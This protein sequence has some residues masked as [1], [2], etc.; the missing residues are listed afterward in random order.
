M[1]RWLQ[2]RNRNC[3]SVDCLQIYRRAAAGHIGNEMPAALRDEDISSKANVA[4]VS[5]ASSTPAGASLLVTRI[6]SKENAARRNRALLKI[7]K[8]Q[9]VNPEIKLA[10][11][12]ILDLLNSKSDYNVAW[13]SAATIAKRLRR[14][15]RSGQ[16]YVKTIKELG[17]FQCEQLSPRD[18]IALCESR[19]GFRPKLDR[20]IK[21]GPNLYIVNP[22]HPLW[23]KQKTLPENV[24]REMGEVIRKIKAMRN[25]KT[26]SHLASDPTN[27][28]KRQAGSNPHRAYCLETIRERLR[29]T[30]DEFRDDDANDQ[31][32]RYEE[33]QRWCREEAW[34]DDV[35]D[36]IDGVANDAQGFKLSFVA[37]ERI[38]HQPRRIAHGR[39]YIGPGCRSGERSQE[40][41]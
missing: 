6:M 2:R 38:S 22:E 5:V 25:A 39:S 41:T 21:Y 11:E 13:P 19:F 18:A 34:N 31:I 23:N 1:N 33:E 17:I 16:W 10:I 9:H 12:V 4:P 30:L 35:R 24:D 37:A 20:C 28:P 36:I 8:A 14:S 7:R 27:R 40:L 29:K 3:R 32:L 26:T 15:R